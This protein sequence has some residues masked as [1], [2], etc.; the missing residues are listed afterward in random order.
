MAAIDLG[1]SGAREAGD[2]AM[3]LAAV[4][5]DAN[6]APPART[7]NSRRFDIAAEDG[8]QLVKAVGIVF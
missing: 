3:V 7:M 4:N 6:Q 5:P 1:R 2:S 8:K